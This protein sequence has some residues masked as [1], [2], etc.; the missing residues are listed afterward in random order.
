MFILF[1][2]FSFIFLHSFVNF[3]NKANFEVTRM[4]LMLNVLSPHFDV[5][6]HSL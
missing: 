5:R 3:A 4:L 6:G 2:N 1:F